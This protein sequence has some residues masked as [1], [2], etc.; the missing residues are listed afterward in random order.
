MA[1]VRVRIKSGNK[2]RL[3]NM[4]RALAEAS[5][6]V[7]VLEGEPTHGRD[8]SP[9]AETF[10]SGRPLKPQTSVAEEAA[11]KEPAAESGDDTPKE[12]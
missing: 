4:G 12:K 3:K 5:S 10:E 2:V 6:N 8:G 9:L 1:L 7:E 11:K